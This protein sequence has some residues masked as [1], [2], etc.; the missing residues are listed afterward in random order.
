MQVRY[1]RMEW[2]SS[3]FLLK[4]VAQMTWLEPVT[5]PQLKSL[6]TQP[7]PLLWL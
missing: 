4:P 5:K 6:R 1:W 7:A 2:T 3:S